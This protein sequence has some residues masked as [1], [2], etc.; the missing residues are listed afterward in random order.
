[1]LVPTQLALALRGDAPKCR[2]SAAAVYVSEDKPK[3]LFFLLCFIK[4]TLSRRACLAKDR[5]SFLKKNR[6]TLTNTISK[7]LPRANCIKLSWI[8]AFPTRLS[9]AE[10]ENSP[11]IQHIVWK[12][13]AFIKP[14]QS[15]AS[16]GGTWFPS[17]WRHS[18]LC[19]ELGVGPCTTSAQRTKLCWWRY[20]PTGSFIILTAPPGKGFIGLIWSSWKGS[21]QRQQVSPAYRHK[22]M[23][24]AGKNTLH[25]IPFP[26]L[27]YPPLL[28][29]HPPSSSEIFTRSTC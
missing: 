28:P 21:T 6:E 7:L 29:Q 26:S 10:R 9:Q 13:D 2:C 19:Q 20:K 12:R 5:G 25:L 8:R 23:Q 15:E 22:K 3:E 27:G 4:K 14:E 17:T 1:M 18:A 11:V 16:Q 24:G